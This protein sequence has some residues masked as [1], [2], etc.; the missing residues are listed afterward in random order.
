MLRG[1]SAPG[2]P[3][4][5]CGLLNSISATA[6]LQQVNSVCYLCDGKT[7]G[8]E[9]AGVNKACLSPTDSLSV[10]K[11]KCKFLARVPPPCRVGPYSARLRGCRPRGGCQSVLM[12]IFTG[13]SFLSTHKYDKYILLPLKG[14]PHI[15]FSS[16]Y[17]LFSCYQDVHL[18]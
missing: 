10:G 11:W 7:L 1:A 18:P 2:R 13:V 12:L 15:P 14:C 4:S 6:N 5:G 3:T 9:I 8:A 16:I 17:L